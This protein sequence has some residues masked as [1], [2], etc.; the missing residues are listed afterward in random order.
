MKIDFKSN[1]KVIT[2]KIQAKLDKATKEARSEIGNMAI[3]HFKKSFD[4]EGFNNTPFMH[5]KLLKKPRYGIY[6]NR[7]ILTKTGALKNSMRYRTRVGKKTFSVLVFSKLPYAAVHNEG[8][9]AGRGNG[10]KMPK[11][12][13]MGYSKELEKRLVTRFRNKL[14]AAIR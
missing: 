3:S 7:K 6:K 13:F 10:F 11:R 14:R 1:A 4:M 9:R 12:Q 8:L 5:W 2:K